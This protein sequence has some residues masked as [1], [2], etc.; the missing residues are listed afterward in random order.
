MKFSKNMKL[1][2]TV[3]AIVWIVTLLSISLLMNK[4][5]LE[6]FFAKVINPEIKGN[7]KIDEIKPIGD[8]ELNT[9]PESTSADAPDNTS[10]LGLSEI[11]IKYSF[12]KDEEKIKA[13][14]SDKTH[15]IISPDG[16]SFI[17]FVD[18]NQHVEGYMATDK[19]LSK[20]R[21]K[22]FYSE[23]SEALSGMEIT[24]EGEEKPLIWYLYFKK[25]GGAWKL[26]MLEN[27]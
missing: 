23:E 22:W 10:V 19:I 7:E 26:F 17:R 12:D 8:K 3:G 6:H 27:E 16:S 4:G 9:A 21:Q 25:A 24:V 20:Y 5:Y 14:L 1:F 15:Y 2:L 11:F 13:L 18:G